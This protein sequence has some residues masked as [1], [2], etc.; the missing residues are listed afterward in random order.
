MIRAAYGR[1]RSLLGRFGE[2]REG[3]AAVEFALIVP[4]MLMLYVGS[5]ELSDLIN[6]DRRITVISVHC[7]R[8]RRP[9]RRVESP[10]AELTDYFSAAEEIITPYST[11][12]LKQ[13]I[14]C[15]KISLDGTTATVQWSKGSGGATER[16]VEP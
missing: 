10:Q 15:V 6:V 7:R 12:G 9:H 1:L 3:A 16:T 13:L 14:T 11:T 4:F 8:P 2:A 5:I